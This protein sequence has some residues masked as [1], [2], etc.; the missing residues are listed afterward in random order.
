MAQ[1]KQVIDY[2]NLDTEVAQDNKP[3]KRTR[4]S[5]TASIEKNCKASPDTISDILTDNLHWFGYKAVKSDDECLERLVEFFQ[6]YAD[7]GGIPTVEKMCLA[8]GVAIQ[9]VWDWQQ[10]TKGSERA[11]MVKRAKNLLASFDADLAIRGLINP[12]VY[13]FRGKNY[14]G[15]RDQTDVTVTHSARIEDGMSPEEIRRRLLEDSSSTITELST[16]TE[17]TTIEVAGEVKV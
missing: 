7:T 9:T 11:E 2:Q 16:A 15:M 10:G 8:L 5:K 4:G 6:Y 3:T 1:K 12:V 13:I 14:Y 17:P